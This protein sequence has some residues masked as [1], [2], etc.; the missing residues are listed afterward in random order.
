MTDQATKRP[1]SVND[2]QYRGGYTVDT[3]NNTKEICF[4]KKI[5]DAA[6]IVQAVNERDALLAQNRAMRDALEI[7]LETW[8]A[9]RQEYPEIVRGVLTMCEAALALKAS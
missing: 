6:L 5:E 9:P 3:E 1:W 2:A 8:N 7:V 4:T